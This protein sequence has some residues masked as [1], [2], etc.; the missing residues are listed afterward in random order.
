M[1]RRWP[2]DPGL[3]I[4]LFREEGTWIQGRPD[5][6]WFKPRPGGM[7]YLGQ[8]QDSL[9]GGFYEKQSWSG[10]ITQFNIW[11]ITVLRMLRNAGQ[12]SWEVLLVGAERWVTNDLIISSDSLEFYFIRSKWLLNHCLRCVERVKL[13]SRN[14]IFR[15]VF[16]FLECPYFIDRPI[17]IFSSPYF[18]M[19]EFPAQPFIHTD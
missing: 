14:K 17:F 18:D 8:D 5:D 9:G 6:T 16:T 12:I 10:L 1:V 11:R 2:V 3:E 19:V 13:G 15:T 4:I 7:L